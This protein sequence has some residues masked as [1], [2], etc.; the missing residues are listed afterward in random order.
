[1]CVLGEHSEVTASVPSIPR[2][3]PK[4]VPL[5]QGV[6]R[7]HQPFIDVLNPRPP[8][9]LL[10]GWLPILR[11]VIL[12][13]KNRCLGSVLDELSISS[14]NCHAVSS[15]LSQGKASRSFFGREMPFGQHWP[16]LVCHRSCQ[17]R[18]G[19]PQPHI[20]PSSSLPSFV[21]SE[22]QSEQ[23]LMHLPLLVGF[24]H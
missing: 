24:A 5:S 14:I 8:I 22:F 7:V 2:L 16:E 19:A 11:A 9:M 4:H 12:V 17:L 18:G 6:Q 13:E 21:V 10:A 20:F 23:L 15:S 1:M 3:S